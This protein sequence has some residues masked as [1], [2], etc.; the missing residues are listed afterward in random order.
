MKY[1][2]VMIGDWYRNVEL[3][4]CLTWKKE[5]YEEI[6]IVYCEPV[7]LTPEILLKN[8]FHSN[9]VDVFEYTG[10]LY[11]PLIQISIGRRFLF[12][13]ID[14]MSYRIEMPVHEVHELQHALRIF[15]LHELANNFKI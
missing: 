11:E 9:G 7:P 5:D 4:E 8:G 15:G 3:E 2:D 10:A 13:I 12:V 6:N 1:N 14:Y